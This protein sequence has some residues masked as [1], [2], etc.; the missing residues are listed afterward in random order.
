MAAAST[1]NASAAL[2]SNQS[3]RGTGLVDRASPHPTDSR[4]VPLRHAH[5]GPSVA[6]PARST[7]ALGQPPHL[8]PT[9]QPA[10]VDSGNRPAACAH[11]VN[12]EHRYPHR[13]PVNTWLSVVSC[14]E[15]SIKLTSVDVPPMSN[16]STRVNHC[17]SR[18]HTSRLRRPADRSTLRELHASPHREPTGSPPF[19]CMMEIRKPRA[20]PTRSNTRPS[21]DPRTHSPQSSKPARIPEIPADL[22]T[23]RHTRL[24]LHHLRDGPAHSS[25]FD[26]NGGNKS[27]SHWPPDFFNRA[28]KRFNSACREGRIAI[29]PS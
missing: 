23:R 22:M 18:P 16:P 14:G 12:I 9:R 4:C 29:V 1:R 6:S 21:T 13:E 8:R 27:Q 28:A 26:M 10:R 17:P 11:R 19:D 15:P 3:L 2:Q 24:P 20:A 7:P 25:N 5:P